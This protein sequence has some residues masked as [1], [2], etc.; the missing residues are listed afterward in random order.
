MR[1][2]DGRRLV[3]N[4]EFIAFAADQGRAKFGDLDFVNPDGEKKH[5]ARKDEIEKI[6]GTDEYYEKGYD[7]EY[8]EILKK[9]ETRK[10]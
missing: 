7:K 4:P 1:T 6:I 10:R 5:L 3:D 8:L 2:P 9:E